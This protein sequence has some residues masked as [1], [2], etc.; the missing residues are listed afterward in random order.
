VLLALGVGYYVVVIASRAWALL[1]E[2][3]WRDKGLAVGLVLLAVIGVAVLVAEIR[4]GMATTRL[5]RD[6]GDLP[7]IDFDD[8][9]AGVEAAPEDWRGW[10]RLAEAYRDGRDSARGRHAMRRA[11]ALHRQDSA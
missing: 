7:V 1:H 5:A 3:R 10:Y 9:K 4:F 6:L 2:P 8:A 11:I